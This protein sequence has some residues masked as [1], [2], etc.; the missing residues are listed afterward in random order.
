MT[1]WMPE[2]GQEVWT[3]EGRRKTLRGNSK[4]WIWFNR[5]RKREKKIKNIAKKSNFHPHFQLYACQL[6][7]SQP[8]PSQT[9]S[10]CLTTKSLI[11]RSKTQRSSQQKWTRLLRSCYDSWA[12]TV[13]THLY[14]KL[15]V[16]P[17]PHRCRKPFM[18]VPALPGKFSQTR[19]TGVPIITPACFWQGLFSGS[20]PPKYDNSARHQ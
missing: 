1:K 19:K 9:T 13:S 12:T 5:N 16:H 17:A 10:C 4:L 6:Q 7:P 11:V 2:L 15:A 14:L 8:A 3:A 20:L 18:G